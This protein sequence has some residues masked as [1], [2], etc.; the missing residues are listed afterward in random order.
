MRHPAYLAIA[1]VLVA[2]CPNPDGLTETS[3]LPD[4]VIVG[5]LLHESASGERLYTLEAD[6]A[7]VFDSEQRSDVVRLKVSFYD[8]GSRV[9]AVLRADR[10]V[11]LNKS[12]DLVA[13]G[14]VVVRTQDS[15]ALW[16]DSLAWT[17]SMRLVR[18]DA[19]VVIETPKG[20]VTGK[21]LV[22]DA[23]F[24]RIQILSPV[25]GSSDCQFDA[26]GGE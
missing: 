23:T 8:A 15:T 3:K 21:G 5:F 12:E 13:H 7:Y 16:T 9:T 17:N 4:Q 6:T 22:S 11:V 25:Q 26:P 2:G 1:L 19:D 20:R 24:S 14:G 10:G 18:T